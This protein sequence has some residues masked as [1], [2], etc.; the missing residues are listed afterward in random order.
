MCNFQNFIEWREKRVECRMYIAVSRFKWLQ[1]EYHNINFNNPISIYVDDEEEVEETRRINK[2]LPVCRKLSTERIMNGWNHFQLQ[3]TLTDLFL[4]AECWKW[5]E[6]M[7]FSQFDVIFHS[8]KTHKNSQF[9][10][11]H[12]VLKIP[13]INRDFVKYLEFDK[14]DQWQLSEGGWVIDTWRS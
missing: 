3:T 13:R 4:R 2:K 9:L 11:S 12:T 1:S 6:I 8:S 14:A 7:F 10:V 5:Q